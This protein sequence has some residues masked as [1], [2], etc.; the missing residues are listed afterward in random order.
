MHRGCLAGNT[1]TMASQHRVPVILTRPLEQAE[2]FARSL[3]W[4]ALSVI[5]PLLRIVP[6][7]TNVDLANFDSFLFTSENGVRAIENTLT[8]E[9]RIAYCVGDRTAEAA[10]SAGF[11]ARSAKGTAEELIALISE[12]APGGRLLHV[13]GAHTRGDV[14][15]RLVANG[16]KAESAAFYDQLAEPLNE[17]AMG[18]LAAQRSLVPLFSPRTSAVFA[19][20]CPEAPKAEVLCLSEAV[21]DALAGGRYADVATV[22]SPTAAAILDEISCRVT[23]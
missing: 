3:P 6:I 23:G 7:K 20:C 15:A 9:G 22:Q 13:H 2:R 19:S 12:Q 4:G 1:G 11:T 10:S 5:S 8:A 14:S 21:A 17:Q 18:V 16:I